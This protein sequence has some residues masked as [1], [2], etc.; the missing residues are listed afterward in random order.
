M[1][2]LPAWI[3][4]PDHTSEA[5]DELSR[6]WSI[7]QLA[8]QIAGGVVPLMRTPDGTHTGLTATSIADFAVEIAEAIVKKVGL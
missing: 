5:Y 2:T 8:A 1:S 6:K 7:A 3:T 4:E